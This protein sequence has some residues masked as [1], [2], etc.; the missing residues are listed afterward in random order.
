MNHSL[1]LSALVVLKNI[2]NFSSQ[3]NLFGLKLSLLPTLPLSYH[4]VTSPP[5][6]TI[7]MIFREHFFH[8]IFC[9]CS[10]W[11]FNI[12]ILTWYLASTMANSGRALLLGAFDTTF[13][14]KRLEEDLKMATWPSHVSLCWAFVSAAISITSA[15]SG[16]DA[17]TW[18]IRGLC[19]PP[20]YTATLSKRNPDMLVLMLANEAYTLLVRSSW[21]CYWCYPPD[22]L[23]DLLGNAA[24][25]FQREWEYI[26]TAPRGREEKTQCLLTHSVASMFLCCHTG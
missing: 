10:D 24:D 20:S 25:A 4:F 18:A 5:C 19:W 6:I 12:T 1:D 22:W 8:V 26:C 15:R 11:P 21:W 23:P 7:A 3:L 13:K 2:C 14:T 16:K 17:S 9:Q